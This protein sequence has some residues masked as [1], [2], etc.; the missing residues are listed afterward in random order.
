MNLYW[1]GMLQVHKAKL[2]RFGKAEVWAA[3]RGIDRH[4]MELTVSDWG[5]YLA[6]GRLMLYQGKWPANGDISSSEDGANAVSGQMG[7]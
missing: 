6:G 5:H 2:R 3:G 4:P 7:T 1:V